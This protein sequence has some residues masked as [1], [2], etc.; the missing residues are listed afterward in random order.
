ML[1]KLCENFEGCCVKYD[2]LKNV[3]SSSKHSGLNTTQYETTFAKVLHAGNFNCSVGPH[4]NP[5]TL[6]LISSYDWLCVYVYKYVYIYIYI[7]IYIYIIYIHHNCLHTLYSNLWVLPMLDLM[8]QVAS[9][10]DMDSHHFHRCISCGLSVSLP[11]SIF[12]P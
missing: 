5:L 7:E 2:T 1:P 10:I 6:K 9:L 8:N 11:V 4:S 12:P 3:E